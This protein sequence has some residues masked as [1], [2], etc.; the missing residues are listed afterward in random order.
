MAERPCIHIR[1]A[2]TRQVTEARRWAERAAADRNRLLREKQR[3]GVIFSVHRIDVDATSANHLSSGS[4][5]PC[6][7]K[8]AGALPRAFAQP[9]PLSASVELDCAACS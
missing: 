7:A 5:Q 8:G 3:L 2:E 4:Q 6:T 9:A 1:C